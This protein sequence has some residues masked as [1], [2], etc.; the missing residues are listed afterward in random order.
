MRARVCERCGGWGCRWCKVKVESKVP[1][2]AKILIPVL[3]ATMFAL[4]AIMLLALATP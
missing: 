2:L 4:V 1:I 3:Y